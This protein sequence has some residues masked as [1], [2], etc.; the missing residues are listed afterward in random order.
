V[1]YLQWE[2][3]RIGFKVEV[4]NINE[5]YLTKIRGEL[6]GHRMGF[7]YRSWMDAAQFCA[8]NKINLEEAL[9]WADN[10]ISGQFIGREDFESYQ[11][12]AQVLFAMGKDDEANAIMDKAIKLPTA[13]I[14][15]IHQYGRSLLNAGK[16]EKAME[17]FKLNRQL[18]PEDKFTTFVGLA[19]GYAALGDKKNA[20]KNWEIAIKNLPENQKG[21]LPQYEAELKKLKG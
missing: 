4:P 21:F 1:A 2:K 7:N 20:I 3:K 12:K 6:Y 9:V 19:R 5:L 14:P 15:S 10:A 11:T 8:Q 16:N 17:V 18:H 13:S